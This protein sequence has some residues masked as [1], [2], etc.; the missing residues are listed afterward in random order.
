MRLH[1]DVVEKLG[2]LI[3]RLASDQDGEVVATARAILRTLKSA[4][5]DLHDVVAE[6]NKAPVTIERVV[7]R[8]AEK[9]DP[10]A[11]IY[12]H[13]AVVATCSRLLDEDQCSLTEKE[14]Q[15]VRDMNALAGRLGDRFHLSPKQ[16]LWLRRLAEEHL[17]DGVRV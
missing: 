10:E 17:G 8:E 12:G 1:G 4:G 16:A 9:P 3:P 7:Y 13:A 15:F 14:A 5:A 2:K 6:L 11:V